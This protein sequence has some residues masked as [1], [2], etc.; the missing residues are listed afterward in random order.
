MKYVR[1]VRQAAERRCAVA[2]V[3]QIDRNMAGP[4]LEFRF[5]A[6]YRYDF[7]ITNPAQMPDQVSSDNTGCTGN[8]SHFFSRHFVMI[9]Y[10]AENTWRT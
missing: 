3:Q 4:A 2:A 5:A 8:E 10:R 9:I 1:D 7:P 6:R